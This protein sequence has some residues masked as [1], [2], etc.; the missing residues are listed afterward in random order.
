MRGGGGQAPLLP[1]CH[2]PLLTTRSSIYYVPPP[3]WGNVGAPEE[4]NEELLVTVS[5]SVSEKKNL[6][7]GMALRADP[8]PQ[9]VGWLVQAPEF[10]SRGLEF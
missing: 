7:K 5:A 10:A 4:K 3:G 1:L 9:F 6:A 8:Y 2:L